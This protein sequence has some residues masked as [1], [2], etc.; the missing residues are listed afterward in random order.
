LQ[1]T[2]II[3]ET[4]PAESEA[5]IYGTN[6]LEG[7]LNKGGEAEYS[8]ISNVGRDLTSDSKTK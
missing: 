3:I 2:L 5:K 6:T 7:E 8:A 1:L 4:P